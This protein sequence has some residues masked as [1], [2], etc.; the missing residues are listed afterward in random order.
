[1]P[2]SA[3]R[4]STSCS[5][6]P[7]LRGLS[8]SR[9]RADPAPLRSRVL[10]P[11]RGRYNFWRFR[12]KWERS[13]SREKNCENLHGGDPVLRQRQHGPGRWWGRAQGHDLVSGD[14]VRPQVLARPRSGARGGA[15]DGPVPDLPAGHVRHQ[16]AAEVAR[17]SGRR[18]ARLRQRRR[19]RH[20]RHQRSGTRQ[21][22]VQEP[23]EGDGP[24]AVRGRRHRGRCRPDR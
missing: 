14:P 5:P 17:R 15:R 4:S 8:V 12:K 10:W 16:L 1:M 24:A 6:S 11:N 18:A 20:L 13:L 2:S 7:R 9:F 3:R 23:L 19:P 22:P 21:Q